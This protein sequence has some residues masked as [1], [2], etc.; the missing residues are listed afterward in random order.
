LQQ[1]LALLAVPA[2]LIMLLQ[3]LLLLFGMGQHG[4]AD[5]GGHDGGHGG[6]HEGDAHPDHHGAHHDAGLRIF[7][8]R[9]FVAFFSIFGWL[10]IVLTE[11][12]LSIPFSITA[13][14]LG[15]LAAMFFMAWFFRSAL[16]LQ[17][18]GNIDMRNCL[19]K[20]AT[21]YIPIPPGRTGKGKV[22]LT[23]QGRFTE[24]DAMTDSSAALKTG[25]EVV[26]TSVSNQN[27]LCVTPLQETMLNN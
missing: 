1:V 6:G 15:G 20:N 4:E 26:V 27:V 22:T 9:A 11:G 3:T 25:A 24:A 23:V 8:V 2:T 14:F 19:G 5:G 18:A 17:S 21:V 16:R 10:G 12:G 13:A 7:T